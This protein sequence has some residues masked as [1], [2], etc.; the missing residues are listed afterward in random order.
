MN[1]RIRH[2]SE[3]WFRK[4]VVRSIDPTSHRIDNSIDFCGFHDDENIM[5]IFDE[6][7]RQELYHAVDPLPELP[8]GL[9]HLIDF[10][11]VEGEQASD[12][13]V[14]DVLNGKIAPIETERSL[15]R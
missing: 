9:E 15:G 8:K 14:A 5:S 11:D 6:R 10:L 3:N 4:L 7:E 12:D 1:S 13:R 2:G